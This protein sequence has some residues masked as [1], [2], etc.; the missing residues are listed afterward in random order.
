MNFAI[1]YG[2]LHH[3]KL[4]HWFKAYISS[5]FQLVSQN[6]Q[7]LQIFPVISGVPQGNNLGLLLFLII[8]DIP[9][10][11]ST[12]SMLLYADDTKQILIYKSSSDAAS[13]QEDLSSL[14]K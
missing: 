1:N 10:Y 11:V 8:N 13:L 9:S 3:W 14:T 7:F 5:R 4:W 12:S 2:L 6:G